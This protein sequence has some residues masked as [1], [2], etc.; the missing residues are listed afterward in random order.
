M[1]DEKYL[2]GA[3]NNSMEYS[4]FAKVPG[5]KKSATQLYFNSNNRIPLK[6]RIIKK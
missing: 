4:V 6:Y 5:R 1:R 2:Q 3:L